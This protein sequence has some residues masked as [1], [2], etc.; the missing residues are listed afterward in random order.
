MSDLFVTDALHKNLDKLLSILM[1]AFFSAFPKVSI[2]SRCRLVCSDVDLD[3]LTSKLFKSDVNVSAV[4]INSM[5]DEQDEEHRKSHR[6][7]KIEVNMLW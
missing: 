5:S 4:I 1:D 3:S 7:D 2:F 6:L